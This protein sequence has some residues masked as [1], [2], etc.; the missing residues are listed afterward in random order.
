MQPLETTRKLQIESMQKGPQVVKTVLLLAAPESLT[1]YRDGG[2][3]W[4]VLEALCHLR[5]LEQI[6]WERARLTVEQDFPSLPIADP[7]QLARE[8]NY[9]SQEVWTVFDDWVANRQASLRYF[10]AINDGDWERVGN[11]PRRGRMTLVDQVIFI[12]WHDM[13]HF[14]QITRILDQKLV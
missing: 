9:N 5:D 2:S 10:Q 3:G 13:N 8:R 7:D 11:H 12:A 1:T 6:F 14:E 4:T